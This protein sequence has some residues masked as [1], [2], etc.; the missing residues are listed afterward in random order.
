MIKE[1]LT[2]IQAKLE[3]EA[4]LVRYVDE[5]WGQLEE[6]SDKPPAKWPCVLLDVGT[7]QW[8]NKGTHQQTGIATIV[9]DVATL[10]LTNT[11]A[12]APLLQKQQAWAVHEVMQQV[13]QLLHSSKPVQGCGSLSRTGTSRVR[14]SDGIQQ[15][16]V[17]YLCTVAGHWDTGYTMV[18][19]AEE[20][21]AVE[22]VREL[23]NVI[24]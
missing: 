17:T 23:D 3:A 19:L 12:K 14:R 21:V 1:I 7:I 24:M 10:K 15:Y 16:R 6:Y 18:N 4:T 8:S 2:A 20:E 22:V 5:N 9:L 13:H 11:S